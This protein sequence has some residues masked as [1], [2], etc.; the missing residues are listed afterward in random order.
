MTTDTIKVLVVDSEPAGERSSKALRE[1]RAME[2]THRSSVEDA[3]DWLADTAVDCV[4]CDDGLADADGLECLRTVRRR[5]GDVPFVIL[6]ES[7]TQD[8]VERTL[9]AEVAEPLLKSG[10]TADERA[11]R[12]AARI[13][14]VVGQRRTHEAYERKVERREERL[15]E[16][17]SVV[18]HDLRNPLNVAQSSVELIRDDLDNDHVDRIDR[19][20]TRIDGIIDDVVTLVRRAGT[21][22][23]PSPVDVET[24]SR[25]AWSSVDTGGMEVVVTADGR[26]EADAGLLTELLANLF[27]NAHEHGTATTVT[28]E[29]ISGG[30][31]ERGPGFAVADDGD[32]I[33][34]SE[35]EEVFEIGVSTGR[36]GAG[37]GL[38]IV[39]EVANAHGW[40]VTVTDSA[41]GGAR[42]E[43]A[44]VTKR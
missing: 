18:S 6:T 11:A 25:E 32:G 9:A 36:G 22:E 10:A 24:M 1:E 20:L 2:V 26:I 15:G 3:L 8:V 13:E 17:T 35:R 38:S 33:P 42:F 4:V 28:V 27:E 29:P 39:R 37:L 23:T 16:F 14:S 19:S 43:I 31:S 44:G 30:E 41:A 34:P 40:T 21:V 5:H 7:S 12:L